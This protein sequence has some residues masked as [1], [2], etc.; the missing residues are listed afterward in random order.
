MTLYI[1]LSSESFPL[2]N[3]LD[4]NEQTRANSFKFQHLRDGFT[5]AHSFKR[6]ILS[7]HFPSCKAN[8]WSF[9]VLSNGKPQVD[10]NNCPCKVSPLASTL[11]F[12]LSHSGNVVAVASIEAMY[13]NSVGIDVECYK[14]IDSMNDIS[15]MT[16]HADE[17]EVLEKYK[18]KRKGFYRLWTAKEA[19]LKA[20]GSGL[21]DNI[22]ELNC[23][24]A[25]NSLI[26]SQVVWEGHQYHVRVFEFPWGV[27]SIAWLSKLAISSIRITD[28]SSGKPIEEAPIYSTKRDLQ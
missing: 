16:F 24:E 18:D 8:E 20:H 17:Q 23:A 21:V 28:W 4:E 1:D 7:K 27:V 11:A 26:C 12:N 9:E 13:Q 5:F 2:E 19:L 15:K 22:Q 14:D 6:F 25:L 3:T 10:L